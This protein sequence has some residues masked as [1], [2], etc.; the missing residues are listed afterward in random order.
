MARRTRSPARPRSA[1]SLRSIAAPAIA[2]LLGCAGGS[3][4]DDAGDGCRRNDQCDEDALESC[5]PPGTQL[6]GSCNAPDH[7]C[8]E[9]TPCAD[10][11]LCVEVAIPCA[12]VEPTERRC[13]PPCV[14]DTA[15]GSLERC[16]PESGLCV[17]RQCA[18]GD[19]CPAHFQCSGELCIRRTCEGDD[20]C[21]DGVCVLGACYD[22]VGFCSGPVP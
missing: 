10:G 14:D 4:G 12:C 21:D 5:V 8:D 18:Q 11:L 6:C 1:G 20:A 15:C 13:L 7:R 9:A 17:D 2:L 19:A 16:D 22:G 3:A